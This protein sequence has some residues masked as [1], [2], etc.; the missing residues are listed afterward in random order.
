MNS[1]LES[2]GGDRR[3][4]EV[5]HLILCHAFLG[6]GYFSIILMLSR[7]GIG[8]RKNMTHPLCSYNLLKSAMTWLARLKFSLAVVDKFKTA[9]L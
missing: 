7:S 8:N 6:G 1:G 9:S 5:V 3:C 4:L 2:V